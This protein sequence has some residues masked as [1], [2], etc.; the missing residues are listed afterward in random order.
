MIRVLEAFGEPISYGG[1][2]IYVTNT[3]RHITSEELVIDYLTPYYS[4]N[5][6]IRQF[7][8]QRGGSIYDLNVI[9]R[10][11]KLRKYEKKPIREFLSK[12]P[13]D[14]IHVHSGSCSML[15]MYARL[16]RQAGIGKIILHSHC[17]RGKSIKHILAQLAAGP[18]ISVY[19]SDYYACSHEAAIA[20]FPR[21]IAEEKTF[22]ARNG[23]DCDNFAFNQSYRDEIRARYHITEDKILL[24]NVGRLAEQKNQIF[25]LKLLKTLDESYMLLLVGSGDDKPNLV[26]Y[27]KENGL[28][29][30][31]IL[32]DAND[33]V[34]K[35]YQAMDYF[36][37]PS[38]MEGLGIVAVEAQASG[39]PVITSEYIP[40]EAVLTSYFTRLPLDT[41]I[42]RREVMK[43][44]VRNPRGAEEVRAAGYD[45]RS[46]ALEIES[47]YLSV[48]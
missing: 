2:E 20:K 22:I 44:P 1:E 15:A 33:E 29:D 19:A 32:V 4:N 17:S 13:Y 7:V 45:I 43:K 47:S 5:K 26:S 37:L 35:Y 6:L 8:E 11:G 46:T 34:N 25:L 48:K 21:R 24:G 38:F 16:A 23:I 42:W 9:F 3:L 18:S 39:L 28:T 40:D 30:R 31:V 10:P 12:H 36:M 14:V 27:A 41:R